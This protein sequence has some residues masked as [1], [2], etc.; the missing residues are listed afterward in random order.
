MIHYTSLGVYVIVTTSLYQLQL[1]QLL[2]KEREKR[3]NIQSLLIQIKINASGNCQNYGKN[4]GNNI[5][6]S[7]VI[8]ITGTDV[9]V[10]FKGRTDFNIPGLPDRI[11]VFNGA[12]SRTGSLIFVYELYTVKTKVISIRTHYPFHKN[13]TLERRKIILLDCFQVRFPNIC[14]PGCPVQSQILRDSRVLK[15]FPDIHNGTSL[16]H[17]T[18]K[19]A[20]GFLN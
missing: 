7:M 9:S 5:Q 4:A 1:G 18:L 14:F 19:T 6:Y 12:V 3:I 10:G 17:A 20:Y 8:V 2:E 16:H 15:N 11:I 13:V